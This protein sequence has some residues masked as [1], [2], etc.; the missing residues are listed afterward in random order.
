MTRKLR[1][2]ALIA[3]VLLGTLSGCTSDGTDERT[4]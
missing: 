2:A 1:V 4:D 3:T